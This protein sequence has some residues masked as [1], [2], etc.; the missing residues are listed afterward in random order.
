MVYKG[1]LRK[2]FRKLSEAGGHFTRQD[3]TC[4]KPA[5]TASIESSFEPGTLWSRSRDLATWPSWPVEEQRIH[6]KSVRC[7]SPNKF[8]TLIQRWSQSSFAPLETETPFRAS[9]IRF[10]AALL[11][12]TPTP[13]F[14][15]LHQGVELRLPFTPLDNRTPRRPTTKL[16]CPQWSIPTVGWLLSFITTGAIQV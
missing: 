1:E 7:L 8:G 11:V 3:L 10:F 9:L 12:P 6:Y 16:P 5:N 15:S 14:L 2:L 4:A 13:P